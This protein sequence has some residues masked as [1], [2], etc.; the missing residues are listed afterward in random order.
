MP[1]SLKWIDLTARYYPLK[2]FLNY[3]AGIGKYFIIREW[4]G[5][6]HGIEGRDILNGDLEN[7]FGYHL[8]LGSKLYKSLHLE[9]KY[10]ILK[11]NMNRE[12]VYHESGVIVKEKVDVNL[13]TLFVMISFVF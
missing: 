7:N 1:T 3:G 10:L 2:S 9:F 12:L 6:A 4:D 11:T 8:I 5:N 13:N